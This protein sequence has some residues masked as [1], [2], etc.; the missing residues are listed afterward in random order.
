MPKRNM[1]CIEIRDDGSV[2]LFQI[3]ATGAEQRDEIAAPGAW[4]DVGRYPHIDHAVVALK[5]LA[6]GNQPITEADIPY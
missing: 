6:T 5:N 3:S 1:F 4:D 2:D